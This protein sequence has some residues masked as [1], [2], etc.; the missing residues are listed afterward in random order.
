M[1]V[2]AIGPGVCR[3]EAKSVSVYAIKS[4]AFVLLNDFT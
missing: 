3:C 1:H 4:V 2:A